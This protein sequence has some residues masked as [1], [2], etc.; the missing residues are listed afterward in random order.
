MVLPVAVT[1]SPAKAQDNDVRA[2]LPDDPDDVG[3]DAVVPPLAQGLLHGPGETEVDRAR[4][5]LPGAVDLARRQ[6]LLGA[7]QAELRALLGADQVLATLTTGRRKI[8]RAHVP[9]PGKIGQHARALVVR[10]GA[11]HKHRAHFVEPVKGLLHF[12][13]TRKIG[14]RAQA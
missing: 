4:E 13:G 5:K 3:E 9:A 14:L 1:R 6:Q 7:N 10:M 11:D 2:V 12:D 8:S